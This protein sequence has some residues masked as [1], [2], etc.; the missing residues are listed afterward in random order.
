[1]QIFIIAHH[2][3][4]SKINWKIRQVKMLRIVYVRK[5]RN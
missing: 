3:K 5:S 2:H 1:M 4:L